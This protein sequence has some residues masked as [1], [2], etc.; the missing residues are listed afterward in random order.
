MEIEILKIAGPLGLS[1]LIIWKIVDKFLNTINNHM[2]HDQALHEKTIEAMNKLGD[3]IQ[4]MEHTQQE[5]T[6]VM[7]SVL[8]FLKK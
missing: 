2:V 3:T 5:N 7:E 6:R 1:L 4:S 8:E